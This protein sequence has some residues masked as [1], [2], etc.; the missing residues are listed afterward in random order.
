MKLNITQSKSIKAYNI[1]DEVFYRTEEEEGLQIGYV[2][3]VRFDVKDDM[4]VN[5]KYDIQ[6]K[7][8]GKIYCSISCNVVY[9]QYKGARKQL[10][11]NKNKEEK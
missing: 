11:T 3:A 5:V 4:N 1:G 7:N 9:H 8:N 2:D 6:G 10:Y